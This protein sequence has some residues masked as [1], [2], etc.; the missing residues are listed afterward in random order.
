[1]VGAQ[2]GPRRRTIVYAVGAALA[3]L[4]LVA[5]LAFVNSMSVAR[6]TANA[7]SLHWVNAALGTSALSRA[8]LVQAITFT[9]LEDQDFV[10]RGDR[11]FAV[12]QLEISMGELEHL[13]A[14]GA[15][16]DSAD[17]LGR[18]LAALEAASL[19][20]Q[21]GD[22]GQARDLA[23]GEVESAFLALSSTLLD[24]Q[25]DIQAAIE[26][27]SRSGSALNGWVLFFLILA[28]PGS[29]VSV[30]FVIARRQV[31]EYRDRAA[32]EVEAE[33]EVSRAKDTFIAGISHELRTPLTSIYGFAEM[34]AEGGVRGPEA[35]EEASRVIANEAAEMTRMVNDLLAASRLESTGVEI[36]LAPTKVWD[37]VESAVEP[38]EK[39]GV[40]IRREQCDQWVVADGERLRHVLVNLLSNAF[41]HGGPTKGIEVS[42]DEETV[43]IEVW[44]DGSGVPED[45]MP[46]LFE[47]FINE[48]DSPLLVG[49]IGLGLAVARR[50]S[51]LMGGTLRYQRFGSRTYFVVSLPVAVNEEGAGDWRPSEIEAMSA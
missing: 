19:E 32:L 7:R 14:M 42:A 48:G 6:V 21:G 30:Y 50:L 31:R 28:V 18:Y 20:L 22:V 13:A 33:R 37:V 51:E 46:R 39:T 11:T 47:K 16:H 44:D 29:A 5:G 2:T 40:T 25:N 41:R 10:S 49:S 34:M 4:L 3:V 17:E 8:G 23:V 26:S 1:M 45:K 24:E 27:H 43:D 38:F 35:V 12:S 36:D 15:G 9:Q